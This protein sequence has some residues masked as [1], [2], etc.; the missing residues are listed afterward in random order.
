MAKLGVYK[1]SHVTAYGFAADEIISFARK[2]A[3]NLI[4]MCTHGYSGVK[5]WVLGSVR[6]TV[7]RHAGDPRTGN[8]SDLSCWFWNERWCGRRESN[9]DA[10]G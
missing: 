8:Q 1:V 3:D 9:S 5:R 7:V 2:T 10:V 6:E 4:A